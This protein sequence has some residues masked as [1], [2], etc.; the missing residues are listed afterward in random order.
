MQNFE[1]TM[2]LIKSCKNLDTADKILWNYIDPVLQN[3]PSHMRLKGWDRAA[4][5]L[6]RWFKLQANSI[7]ENGS[8]DTTT[9]SQNGSMPI[10]K[11]VKTT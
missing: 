4:F 1:Q 3:I 11:L 10:H 2:E 8:H 7:P 9:V 5:L 6:E